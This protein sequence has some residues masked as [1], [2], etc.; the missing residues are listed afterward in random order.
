VQDDELAAVIAALNVYSRQ[1]EAPQE[2]VS[3]WKAE[4]RRASIDSASFDELRMTNVR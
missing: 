3:A 1:G 4:A 2:P